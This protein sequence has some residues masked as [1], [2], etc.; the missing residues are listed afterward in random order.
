MQ[1]TKDYL[2][3]GNWF[4]GMKQGY[5]TC[6]YADGSTYQG[7]WVSDNWEGE[8]KFVDKD[9]NIYSG[10][11]FAGMMD[12]KIE[13]FWNNGAT[14][15]GHYHKGLKQKGTYQGPEHEE[16]NGFLAH[17]LYYKGDWHGD[18]P[19]GQGS[20]CYYNKVSYKGSFFYGTFQGEGQLHLPNLDVQ[21][22]GK[23]ETN[24]MGKF[25]ASQNKASTKEGQE[26]GKDDPFSSFS[27]PCHARMG[28][29]CTL[30]IKELGKDYHSLGFHPLAHIAVE[31]PLLHPLTSFPRP[32][33]KFTPKKYFET[34]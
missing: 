18:L 17:V 3:E 27:D 25:T 9:S 34:G 19:H 29:D 8:G 7:E 30:R 20:I 5:G 14:F 15:F 1:R 28:P 13:I 10:M 31:N 11:W 26:K 2:Y 22:F 16:E 24:K 12:G 4:R 21:I 23:W 32:P 6:T 33:Q